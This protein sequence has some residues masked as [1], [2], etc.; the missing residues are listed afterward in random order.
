MPV[1]RPSRWANDELGMH[2]AR[3]GV[4]ATCFWSGHQCFQALAV[5]I[6]CRACCA[7]Q[8]SLHNAPIFRLLLKVAVNGTHQC[9]F[10]NF[11]GALGLQRTSICE[12]AHVPLAGTA[13]AAGHKGYAA[14]RHDCAYVFACKGEG[15]SM[16][17][18]APK[19]MQPTCKTKMST[20]L[21]QDHFYSDCLS[22]LL[23]L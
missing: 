20:V 22:I 15:A 10:Q 11:C 13:R 17:G 6:A 3:I 5:L 19:C 4:G 2:R 14:A 18:M 23:T 16:H 1:W 9:D 12:G 8:R 21:A 7:S